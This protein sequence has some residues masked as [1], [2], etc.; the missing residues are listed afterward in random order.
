MSVASP[1]VNLS[2]VENGRP[3]DPIATRPL[4]SGA[5]SRLAIVMPIASPWAR[6]IANRLSGL[7]WSVHVVYFQ[8]SGKLSGYLDTRDPV[9]TD[10]I[11]EFSTTVAAV[12]AVPTPRSLPLR[13]AHS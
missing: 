2:D 7:G 9:Q 5:G 6:L 12:H 8:P 4:S 3:T 13:L 11:R 10:A 1:T